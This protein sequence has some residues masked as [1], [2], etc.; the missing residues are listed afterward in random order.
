MKAIVQSFDEYKIKCLLPVTSRLRLLFFL[1]DFVASPQMRLLWLNAHYHCTNSRS[2]CW[3]IPY[4][5]YD[6]DANE[7]IKFERNKKWTQWNIFIDNNQL[8]INIHKTFV[9]WTSCVSSLI[10][11]MPLISFYTPWKHQGFLIF[12]GGMERNQ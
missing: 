3:L 6:D 9:I 11:Y 1:T 2:N 4:Y 7:R 12:S 10:R 8:E 5:Y